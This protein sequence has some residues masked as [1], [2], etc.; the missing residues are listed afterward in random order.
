MVVW[1]SGWWYGVVDG[2]VE[3]WMV[4]WSSGGCMK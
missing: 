3:G 1:S 4:A 2:C